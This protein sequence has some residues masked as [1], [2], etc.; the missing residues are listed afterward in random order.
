MSALVVNVV[1]PQ[2]SW[3]TMFYLASLPALL[4][5]LGQRQLLWYKDSLAHSILTFSGDGESRK[6]P[7]TLQL[8]CRVSR[9]LVQNLT[10]A[11]EKT[12][13]LPSCRAVNHSREPALAVVQGPHNRS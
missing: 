4:L 10:H 13:C 12:D 7:C 2:T 5:G 6:L 3:R 9:D 1:L 11:K 8:L